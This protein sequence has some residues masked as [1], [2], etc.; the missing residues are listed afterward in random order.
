M[1]EKTPLLDKSARDPFVISSL[2]QSNDEN[3]SLDVIAQHNR[4]KYYAKLHTKEKLIIPDHVL[5]SYLFLPILPKPGFRQSSL[6]TIFAIWNTMMGTSLLSLPWAL[7]QSGFL[8]GVI[9]L[10]LMGCICLY[11]CYLVLKSTNSVDHLAAHHELGNRT[12][13]INES[14]S[15]STVLCLIDMIPKNS[16]SASVSP[17]AASVF[18][19]IWQEHLTVPLFLVILLLPL[20]SFKSPTFF[21]KFNA[22]GTVS[23][24]YVIAFVCIKSGFWGPHLHFEQEP[25]QEATSLYRAQFP[26]LTGTLALAM[27]I[28]NAI[29]SIV[30]NQEKPQNNV[31]DI[32]IAYSLTTGTYFLIGI[33]FYACFPLAKRCIE[34]VLLD[35]FPSNDVMTFIARLCL[36]FQMITVYPL[37]MYIIRVQTL[38]LFFKKTYPSWLHVFLLNLIVIGFGIV[39][40]IFFPH[41][42]HIIRYVGS[43]SGCRIDKDMEQLEIGSP[44]SKI[45]NNKEQRKRTTSKWKIT[46]IVVSTDFTT[47]AV[48]IISLDGFRPDYY[49]RNIT[50]NI[51]KLADDGVRAEY[52]KSQYPTKTF[53]NHYTIATGLY[54]ES[55][56]IVSNS[57]KSE[58]RTDSF[59]IGGKT[60]NDAKWWKGEPIWVT[61]RM[62]G[63]KSATYFWVGS[64]AKIKGMRPNYWKPYN[65]PSFISLYFEEPDKQGHKFGTNSSQTNNAIKYVDNMV[66][67]LVDGIKKRNLLSCVNIIVVS[68]HGMADISCSRVIYLD[69]M[70]SLS[71]FSVVGQ[72]ATSM[73]YLSNKTSVK[74]VLTNLECKHENLRA[75]AKGSATMPSRIHY[76]NS[77]RI[78]DIVLISD[79][80]WSI[81][82]RTGSCSSYY[83][84]SHGYDN[85]HTEMRSLFLANGPSFK[86]GFVSPPFSNIE[87]YNLICDILEIKPAVNNGTFG[88]LSYLLRAPKNRT[89]GR[90]QQI[91]SASTMPA[92]CGT[93]KINQDEYKNCSHCLIC[94]YDCDVGKNSSGSSWIAGNLTVSEVKS[95]LG[96][97]LPF[98]APTEEVDNTGCLLTQRYYVIGYNKYFHIPNWVAYKLSAKQIGNATSKKLCFR[99]DLRLAM[100][101]TA[102]CADYNS[103]KFKMTQLA[104]SD[105]F[106]F[107]QLALQDSYLL[108]NVVP[109]SNF[110]NKEPGLWYKLETLVA[111]YAKK[112]ENIYV[113]SGS[114][115]D[116]NGDGLRDVNNHTIRWVNDKVNSVAIPTH[117]YKI[118][119]RYNEKDDKQRINVL[120]FVLPH[121]VSPE[122]QIYNWKERLQEFIVSIN[123]I[124]RL[125][126]MRFF[127]S[128]PYP[129]VAAIKSYL[130]SDLW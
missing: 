45:L 16:Q 23:V 100:N 48:I 120:A 22:F 50:P 24:F 57:F 42:G 25:H 34:Q 54:P 64:E 62:Q 76:S 40:A 19:T 37:L 56:G 35:N 21:T 15:K 92:N 53:P 73:L 127:S 9:L 104:P 112:Y 51:K 99:K 43:M 89:T 78:G 87:V 66:G 125:T 30:R 12:N 102:S 32:C 20:S 47:P 31:R 101:Q 26:A 130:P 71:K 94:S 69:Q 36:L 116:S 6:I 33:V 5:P 85:F 84:G 123:D 110:L 46:F 98:G 59:R 83:K 61:A 86:R 75:Y 82:K 96:M 13:R 126:G 74:S 90:E 81:L 72:G 28:H 115:F 38:T 70:V 111:K 114:I 124:E 122:C 63:L 105:Y 80:G 55:H 7:A 4:Y 117:Y 119:T 109:Q 65:G 14:L 95:S 18:Y 58:N 67:R 2:N 17:S 129:H 68:D 103:T 121:N 49:H 113:I 27:Y 3:S 108:S 10:L 1:D 107:D 52:M 11:T 106:M 91:N 29:L 8:L 77:R 41:V 128:L 88:S 97:H 60:A 118:I 44:T 93:I 39:F 79:V